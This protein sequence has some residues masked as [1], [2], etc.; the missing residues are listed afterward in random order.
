M[1]AGETDQA[2]TV[3]NATL[4][5]L[6]V[7]IARLLAVP[8]AIDV[9]L[10][11]DGDNVQVLEINPRFGGG[12][13]CTHLAGGDFPQRIIEMLRGGLPSPVIG[14]LPSG[15][16]MLKALRF[17]SGGTAPPPSDACY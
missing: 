9:D 12:Y 1:R 7:E 5:E 8:G 4:T 3:R 13:P 14:T 15:V 11:V 17:I 6:G 10:F 16:R 2:E